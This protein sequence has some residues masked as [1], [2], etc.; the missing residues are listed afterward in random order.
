MDP[1]AWELTLTAMER[2]RCAD[3]PGWI[4]EFAESITPVERR[5]QSV[6]VLARRPEPESLSHITRFLASTEQA[7]REAAQRALQVRAD[8]DSEARAVWERTC[9]EVEFSPEPAEPRE[10]S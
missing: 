3:V 9:E 4:A 1:Q 7:L 6:L 2:I 10:G 8:W 5:A